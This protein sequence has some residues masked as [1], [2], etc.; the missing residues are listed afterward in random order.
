[1]VTAK[2]RKFLNT[3]GKWSGVA[4]NSWVEHLFVMTCS[5]GNIMFVSCLQEHVTPFSTPLKKWSDNKVF[6]FK[7]S[8]Y[9]HPLVD[10]FTIGCV[11]AWPLNES[12]AGVEL[13]MKCSEVS[14]KIRSIPASLSFKDPATKYRTVKWSTERCRKWVIQF[15][16]SNNKFISS[17]MIVNS[18]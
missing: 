18:N 12:E 14:V 3:L 13:Y 9:E 8:Y 4:G 7:M 1:M 5:W 17:D 2:E 10:H 11:V 6:S 16:F 15:C